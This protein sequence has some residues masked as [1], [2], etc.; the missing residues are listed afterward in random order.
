[1]KTEAVE[2]MWNE[3]VSATGS[4]GTYQAWGFG[5]EDNPEQQTELGRLVLNG[6]KRATTGLYQEYL[7]D[8]EPLPK[9]GDHEII[10]DG[11]GRPL[12]I[13]KTTEVEIRRFGSVD[14][15]FAWVE[16]EGDRSLEYWREAHIRF[17]ERIGSPI[18]DDSLMVLSK[19]DLVWP[20]R[21]LPEASP[22]SDQPGFQ[23]A[24][25]GGR[26]V[27]VRGD[28]YFD[29]ERVSSGVFSSDPMAAVARHGELSGFHI[30][31]EPDGSVSSTRLGPPVSHP[32]Q[33]FG[34]GFN[35]ASHA[36]ETG[37]VVPTTPVVFAKF[38]GCLAGPT[39]DVVMHGDRVDYEGELVVVIGSPARQVVAED[40]WDYIAGLTVGQDFSD[41]DVQFAAE[42]PQFSLGKSFDGFGPIGPTIVSLDRFDDPRD[43]AIETRVN[44]QLRQQ[45]RTSDMVF[46]VGELIEHVSAVVTLYPGDLIFTGTPGG[47][48]YPDGIFLRHGDV[49]TTT[50]EG[51]GT[52]TNR[53]VSADLI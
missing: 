49:V 18:D 31:G 38:V 28:D 25:S 43:L 34:I 44:S 26:A 8:G 4:G 39:A 42:P 3:Y 11:D 30:S 48:A 45:G 5:A 9:P 29:L 32:R 19:F 41:R 20:V 46:S 51:I 40:A 52:L 17:F 47:V 33:I 27:L 14:A 6:P 2:A 12:C 37:S 53:C 35:Y 24:N 21:P 16:G 15:T 10:L 13:I 1:M 22:P 23:L 50:I 7:D 36:A